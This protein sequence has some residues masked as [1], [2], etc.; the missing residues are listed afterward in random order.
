MSTIVLFTAGVE[1]SCSTIFVKFYFCLIITNLV[2]SIDNEI[3]HRNSEWIKLQ[4]SN[5]DLT[6]IKYK[7]FTLKLVKILNRWIFRTNYLINTLYISFLRLFI[8]FL[9][10]APWVRHFLFNRSAI[11]DDWWLFWN[12]T[13]YNIFCKSKNELVN[14]VCSRLAFKSC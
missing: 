10:L 13:I 1:K 14:K 8:W 4:N 2:I 12:V 5:T 7:L 11:I 9:D 6:L 3:S